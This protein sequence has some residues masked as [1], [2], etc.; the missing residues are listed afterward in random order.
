[1]EAAYPNC[2]YP[3]SP[4]NNCKQNQHTELKEEFPLELQRDIPC[5]AVSSQAI[6]KASIRTTENARIHCLLWLTQA[7]RDVRRQGKAKHVEVLR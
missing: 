3:L 4:C 6:H 5:L 7:S 2:L 1:M